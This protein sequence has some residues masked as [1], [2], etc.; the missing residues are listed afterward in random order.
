M[1]LSPML[2]HITPA[3]FIAIRHYADD[4]MPCRFQRMLSP[5]FR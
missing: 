2:S 1:L 4:F 3:A 5:T